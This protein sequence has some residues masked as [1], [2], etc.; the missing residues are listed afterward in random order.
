MPL[1]NIAI[2]D[3]QGLFRQILSHFIKSV[4]TFR[5]IGDFEDGN[6]FWGKLPA[7]YKCGID[8]VIVDIDIHSFNGV[9]LTTLLQSQYPKIKII[10]LSTH[11]NPLIIAQLIKAHVSSYLTKDCNK[12]ELIMAIKACH[13]AGYYYNDKVIKAIQDHS[14]QKVKAEMT[15]NS[16][17]IKISEREKQVLLLICNEF[18]T[19]EI[20]GKLHLSARTID[21]HRKNLLAKTGCRNT[22][23][24]VF[25]AI[26]Y[27]IL[28]P[29]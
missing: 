21:N 14:D 20:S 24:L 8:I 22:A 7:L 15:L 13:K 9:Q 18:N 2:V 17:N 26:K 25:F 5:L 4:D 6:V 16:L 1:I 23:G 12:E 28:S 10:T 11:D 3:G 19:D 29:L 27:L